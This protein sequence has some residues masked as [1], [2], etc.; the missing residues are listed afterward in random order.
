MDGEWLA[1]GPVE[2]RRAITGMFETGTATQLGFG[3]QFTP[4][5]I[6]ATWRSGSW[7]ELRLAEHDAL[8]VAPSALGLHYGQ[9]IFEGLKAYG[10]PDG[11]I[12]LFRPVD[13]AHRFG[14]GARRLAM[15][16]LPAATFVEA[17]L[18][19]VR[20][21]RDSVPRGPGQSLYLRPFMFASEAALAVRPADEY[22][23]GVVASPVD[24]FYREGAD[25]IDVWC[26][27]EHVR[28]VQGGTG[29]VKSAG[30]YA[31]AMVAKLHAMEHGCAEALWL[32]AVHR[33]WIEELGAMNFFCVVRRDDGT[34]ELVTPPLTGTILPGNTRAS[35]IDVAREQ[36][37]AVRERVVAL[38][39]LTEPGGQ[40]VEAFGCGTAAVVSPIAGI[41]HGSRRHPVSDGTGPVTAR[42]RDHL[43]DVQFG[44]VPDDRGWLY[45]V[46][47]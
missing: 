21:D 47:L 33:C 7:S 42:L 6:V 25:A 16:V 38:T 14:R 15:P 41:V 27:P 40:V 8:R 32:D 34:P 28:A 2:R 43:L 19:L 44:R 20:A 5:M 46:D 35:L 26:S 39:E 18:A 45:P 13:N 3:A 24:H 11:S 10:Q 23:F 4:S 1:T 12:A 31:G 22:T 9:A 37:I 30:N 29:E 36:G 17:C